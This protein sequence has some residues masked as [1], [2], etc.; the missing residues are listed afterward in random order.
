MHSEDRKAY[1]RMREIWERRRAQMTPEE[2][3]R[4]ER[5]DGGDLDPPASVIGSHPALNP[6]TQ[7]NLTMLFD[8]Y[9]KNG[10]AGLTKKFDR[11]FPAKTT[12]P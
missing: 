12:K 8:A 4:L 11:I 2:I 5:E 7:E 6:R 3:R 10:E 1:E 9:R